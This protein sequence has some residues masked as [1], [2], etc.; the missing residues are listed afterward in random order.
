[1]YHLTFGE[2]ANC[3]DRC[4]TGKSSFP[5][6]RIL[7]L[8]FPETSLDIGLIDKLRN[9]SSAIPPACI[10]WKNK[11]SV[12][13]WMDHLQ[14]VS[15]QIIK[16][17]FTPQKLVFFVHSLWTLLEEEERIQPED[18]MDPNLMYAKKAVLSREEIE[19]SWF[20][21]LLLYWTIQDGANTKY[22]KSIR[23]DD[24]F[25]ARVKS[26]DYPFQLTM[27][28]PASDSMTISPARQPIQTLPMGQDFHFHLTLTNTGSAVWRRR[29]LVCRT[30][31]DRWACP[32]KCAPREY[33]LPDISPGGSCPCT[34]SGNTDYI[35]GSSTFTWHLED[36]EGHILFPDQPIQCTV[37]CR[38]E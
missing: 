22:K 19:P 32:A 21:S 7:D 16:E 1:M 35:E 5:N 33:A 11:M 28:A 25:F 15:Q 27:E 2:I 30:A 26:K 4:K 20:L 37:I 17:A 14:G 38:M 9:H 12:P 3:I 10:E 36:E 8:L 6:K 29:K 23:K 13:Q 34:L 31:R 24:A 18:Y